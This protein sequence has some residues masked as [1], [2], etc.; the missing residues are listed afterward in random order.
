[1]SVSFD[2]DFQ[3]DESSPWDYK[4][5]P[6]PRR[7][8][9]PVRAL[10]VL[11]LLVVVGLVAYTWVQRRLREVEK[12]EAEL[13]HV[14]E[15]EL[16]TIR[17]G[18][19]ELFRFFQDPLAPGWQSLQVA[20]YLPNP[21]DAKSGGFAPA[22]G[23]SPASR[24]IEIEKV[25]VFG[26]SGRVELIQWFHP[27]QPGTFP[28]RLTWFYRLNEDGTWYHTSPPDDHIGGAF[29]WHGTWLEIYATALEAK[30]LNDIADD[31]I[32]SVY[33]ACLLLDCSQDDHY[34]L[35]FDDVLEPKIYYVSDRWKLPP[36][37]LTGIPDDAAARKVWVRALKLWLVEALTFSRVGTLA[38]LGDDPNERV[39]YRQ[40]VTRLQA[41]LG[42][43][44]PPSPDVEALTWAVSELELYL[45]Q[46]LWEARYDLDNPWDN[47]LMDA[48]SIA[49]LGW[50]EDQVGAGRL[51]ELFQALRRGWQLD[52]ALLSLYRL[53]PPT[54]IEWNAY[55]SELTGV[56]SSVPQRTYQPL[57][58]PPLPPRSSSPYGDQIALVCDGRVWVGDADGS[59]QVPLT[60]PGQTF[61]GLLWSPDG[62]WLLT[63]WQHG[64][65]F[66]DSALYL[67]A[68]DGSGGRLLTDDPGLVMYPLGWSPDGQQVIC[69]IFR[70]AT[71]AQGEFESIDVE[72]GEI[73][74][75]PGPSTW[76]PDGQRLIYGVESP[77]TPG[78]GTLWLADANWENARQIVEQVDIW[79]WTWSPDSSQLALSLVHGDPTQNTIALYDLA[80]V[81]TTP[82]VTTADLTEALLVATRDES[83]NRYK[84]F[85]TDDADSDDLADKL[86]QNL[87][88]TGWSADGQRLVVQAK[89]TPRRGELSTTAPTVVAVA[90]LDGSLP[91]VLVYSDESPYGS[92]AWS[93]TQPE[94]L[95]FKWWAAAPYSSDAGMAYLF[96]LNAGPIYTATHNSNA[97][98]SP[99]GAW[100]AFA[101]QGP[102]TIVDQNGD[103]RFTLERGGACSDVAWN[104]AADLDDL[105]QTT[106]RAGYNPAR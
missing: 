39:I 28:F 9:W 36:L 89:V 7:R 32:L 4:G 1:M 104:P 87:M 101:G 81:S 94:Q 77:D 46:N 68:A 45:P 84:N 2:W 65:P 83:T 35:T 74:Q 14:V 56:P 25:R 61:S 23:L 42:L 98:W 96:D 64:M 52:M 30:F 24:P 90:P 63:A 67:L 33:R 21:D 54:E 103:A 57:E 44:E 76:S 80:T 17:D 69:Y 3:D 10:V 78:G 55:L 8:S 91:R 100:A 34:V 85:I 29:S 38:G 105:G 73:R 82:L 99:D 27:A 102:V 16:E 41:E 53:T 72:T 37:Y 58:P 70:E 20:R 49:L 59:D 15:T 22:P 66:G 50:I 62:R 79:R 43:V 19:A 47:R 26:R 75:L 40:L 106:S 18:D 92:A 12:V 86:F 11:A 95:I 88:A 93:P 51:F 5:A 71:G 97:A 48:R 60:T 31:L 13:R 6:S